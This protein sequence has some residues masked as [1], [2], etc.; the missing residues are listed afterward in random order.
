MI[1]RMMKVKLAGAVVFSVIIVIMIGTL[2]GCRS[3][4]IGE[5]TK[6]PTLLTTGTTTLGPEDT[7]TPTPTNTP[8]PSPIPTPTPKTV[9]VS[10]IGDTTL[11]Q[12]RGVA[13]ASYSFQS[14]VGED[15]EYPFKNTVE[16]LGQ[17]DMTLANFE[18]TLTTSDSYRDKEFTFKGPLEYVQILQNGSIEAV[19]LANNHSYDYYDAGLRD[20][21]E[22]LE[23]AGIVW[24]DSSYFSTYEVNGVK[25]GMAGFLFPYQTQPI[26]DAIDELREEGCDIVIISCHTGVERMYEPEA[27]AVTLAHQIIDYGADIYVGHHPHRLQPIEYY[28]GHYILYSLSNFCFGGQPNLT[29]PETCIVQCRF[30]EKEDGSYGYE[31]TVIPYSMTSTFPE[32]DYCPVAY[33]VDSERYR[34]VMEKL[35]W[36]EE[37]E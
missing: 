15:Y 4:P 10:F 17:D 35:H 2:T 22:T 9:L 7:P 28:N 27:S 26:Y 11:G 36:S 12:N 14:V 1:G 23:A 29:D 31:L 37:S 32:N 19:N 16:V 13:P 24:S 33:E 34:S 18:G 20:T 21:R 30:T 8:T 3:L 6:E 25:I 5:T